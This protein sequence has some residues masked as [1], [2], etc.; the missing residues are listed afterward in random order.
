MIQ[1][2]NLKECTGC[3]ACINACTHSA[4]SMEYTESG[5]TYPSINSAKCVE[6]RLCEQSC[7]VIN[8]KQNSHTPTPQAYAMWNYAYRTSSSSGGAFSA[9]ARKVIDNGGIVYGAAFD[10]NLN[11]QH[12]GITSTKD[13]NM[14]QGSK[15][16][17]SNIGE[18]FKE[19]RKALQK[20]TPVLFCGTPCQVAGLKSYLKKD[21]DMLLTIDLVCHGV[22]SQKIFNSYLDK[23]KKQLNIKHIDDFKFRKLNGWGYI[24]RIKTENKHIN[25]YG[26][27]NLYMEAFNKGSIFRESCYSCPY[28]KIPRQG[29]CTIADFWGIGRHRHAFKHDVMKGVSLILVNSKKGEKA[30]SELQN[31]FLE[32]RN[33]EEALFE[34]KNI[35]SPSQFYPLRNEV[36]KSF[37]D[38]RSSLSSINKQFKLTDNSLKGIIKIY[39]SKLG[40]FDFIKR[41]YNKYKSL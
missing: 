24:T 9:Y 15:Y 31:S 7:P 39:A 13:L 10:E 4:I 25:L 30:T 3:A 21:Y 34:N 23:V 20:N 12:I 32:K 35:H 14:L 38:E 2:A 11:L 36:I 27:K 26:E 41:I 17:Q 19:I 5:F 37:L 6:C 28:A 16:L 29:D 8:P 22:P 1:L 33:L 40:I 18:T